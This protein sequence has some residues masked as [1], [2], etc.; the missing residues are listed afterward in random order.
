MET[1]ERKSSRSCPG[2]NADD[3]GIQKSKRPSSV[4]AG[5]KMVRGRYQLPSGFRNDQRIVFSD[6]GMVFAT[7][8]HYGTFV[9][10]MIEENKP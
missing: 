2:E 8:D 7:Y 5:E 6:D 1:K 10:I 3:G 4:C 9:E